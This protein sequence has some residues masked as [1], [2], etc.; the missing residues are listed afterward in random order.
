MFIR[1]QSCKVFNKHLTVLG[2]IFYCAH[3]FPVNNIMVS[4]QRSLVERSPTIV[5][6][7]RS[8]TQQSC[9]IEL[10]IMQE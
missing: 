1:D 2:L 5:Q 9:N 4:R 10:D 3:L 8:W 7:T 6:S